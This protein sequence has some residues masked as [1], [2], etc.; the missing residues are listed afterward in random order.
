[1]PDFTLDI[2]EFKSFIY[3]GEET[4]AG[5]WFVKRI[6]DNEGLSVRYAGVKNNPKVA[7]YLDG[8]NARYK[9]KYGI[10][11]EAIG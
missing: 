11:S 4:E 9:L 10:R 7:G 3:M 6:D 8:W 2:D 1:M 5:V